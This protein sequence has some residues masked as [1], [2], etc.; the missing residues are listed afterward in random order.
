MGRKDA[1]QAPRGRQETAFPATIRCR[2]R[3]AS[4]PGL[5][6][7]TPVTVKIFS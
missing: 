4:L 1:F 5:E 3:S 2:F 7:A 6:S